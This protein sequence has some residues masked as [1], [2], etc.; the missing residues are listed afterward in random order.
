MGKK[1]F[2][3]ILLTV[4]AISVGG[5]WDRKELE[6]MGLVQTLGLD[7]AENNEVMVTCMIAIPSKLGATAEGGGSVEGP[8]VLLISM[9]A[10]SIYEAFNLMNTTVNREV[11]LLQNQALIIGEDIAKSGIKP[12]IDNLLRFRDMRR[13]LLI[14]VCK[15]KAADIMK[16]Q[17]KLDPNPAEYFRDL[18][19]TSKRTGMFPLTNL[20]DFIRRYQSSAQ[21]NY[22]PLLMEYKPSQSSEPPPQSSE[23]GESGNGEKPE[24]EEPTEVRIAGTAVFKS[25]RLVGHLDLYET[26][27]LQIITNQ[28]QEAFLTLP[29]PLRKETKITFRLT[30]SKPTRIKYIKNEVPSFT[31]DIWMEASL[32]SIESTIDYTTPQM[33]EFLRQKIAAALRHRIEKVIEKTQNDFRSD[34][35]GFGQKVRHSMLTT[36]EW[37]RY[38]WPEKYT[39]SKVN[40]N[41]H[42]FIR[43]VGIQFQP[44]KIEQ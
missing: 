22:A 19:M 13:T 7:L 21:E 36:T 14:F 18:V 37:E 29:D 10:P 3:A 25:N 23:N 40:I 39:K 28:F 5:C 15:G 1:T 17:P 8:G 27:V 41:V 11:T 24:S 26:Q 35:F 32:I 44:P 20:H 42:V 4:F 9:N 31:V 12:W 30:R 16:I 2:L 33:E 34:I 6:S 38:R 43:R